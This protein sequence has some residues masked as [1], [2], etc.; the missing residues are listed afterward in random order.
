LE[1]MR[2]REATSE[3]RAETW[4][5]RAETWDIRSEFWERRVS[6]IWSMGD[7]CGVMGVA[8][9]MGE[10]VVGVGD[11]RVGWEGGGLRLLGVLEGEEDADGVG[12]KGR[13]DWIGVRPRWEVIL[14]TQAR[15][16]DAGWSALGRGGRASWAREARD[17]WARWG[18]LAT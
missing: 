18:S 14:S 5:V 4:A 11:A 17:V 2:R 1:I 13:E 3:V 8:G 16:V 6:V 15:V 7:G 9:V 12:K 10:V